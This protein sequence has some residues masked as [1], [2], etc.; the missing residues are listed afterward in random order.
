M[1]ELTPKALELIAR[2]EAR[3]KQMRLDQ[4]RLAARLRLRQAEINERLYG[5]GDSTD[6][7]PLDIAD[8]QDRYNLLR[9]SNSNGKCTTRSGT[10]RHFKYGDGRWY[11]PDQD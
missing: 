11:Y 8:T 10:Y 4:E 9:L 5:G 6:D 2:A 1:P 7:D 3:R